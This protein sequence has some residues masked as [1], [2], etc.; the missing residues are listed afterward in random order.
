MR[1]AELIKELEDRAGDFAEQVNE[2]TA[3]A[4][5][6][7]DRDARLVFRRM[8]T[9]SEARQEELQYVIDRLR[10]IQLWPRI[11]AVLRWHQ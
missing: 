5:R 6:T 8:A 10:Q 4:N 7:Q 3:L 11:C 9:E 2:F 1:L